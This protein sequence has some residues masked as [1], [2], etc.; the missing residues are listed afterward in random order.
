MDRAQPDSAPSHP[1]PGLEARSKCCNPDR[2]Q[3]QRQASFDSARTYGNKCG[4]ARVIVLLLI[5][6]VATVAVVALAYAAWQL[7]G[8]KQFSADRQQYNAKALQLHDRLH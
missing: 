3:P 8:D 4:R 6:L 1:E 5:A 7:L 2:M